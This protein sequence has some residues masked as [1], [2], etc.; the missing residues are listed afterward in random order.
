[1]SPKIL[2]FALLSLLVS[3]ALSAQDPTIEMMRALTHAHGPSGYEGPVGK[4][5]LSYLEP[6]V[7]EIRYDGLGSIIGVKKGSTDRPKVMIAAH[8]DEVGF[9]VKYIDE[10]GYIYMNPLG[11]WLNNVLLAQRWIIMTKSKGPILGISGSKTPHI[12]SPEER[13]RMRRWQ[14]IFLDIGASSREEAMEK[15][16]VRQGDPIAPH[17]P[18]TILNGTDLYAAKAWD[19]RVGWPS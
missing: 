15:F 19:D 14:E 17:S 7:D 4:V 11:G 1:M 13:N 2:L 12:M 10:Q 16:G 9:M 18:F 8:M 3:S 5:V 6:V